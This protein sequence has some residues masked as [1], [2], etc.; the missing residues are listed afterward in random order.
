MNNLNQAM[1][2][3]N[4]IPWD[5]I[6]TMESK[7]DSDLA[8]E[9]LRRLA[10]FYK[11]ESI[12]PLP[13]L[14]SNIAKLLGDVDNELEV[15]DYCHNINAIEFLN[16]HTFPR[17]IIEYYLQLAKFIDENSAYSKYLNVYTPLIRIF[18]N[19]GLVVFRTRDLEVINGAFIPLNGWYERFVEKKPFIPEED[20][21][22]K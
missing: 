14:I 4:Q 1:Q 3:I 6:G 16:N 15:I 20:L 11:D 18:E 5:S 22:Q 12:T 21:Q 9:Y 10:L 2:R 13:P 7:E 8:R 19:G 17:K